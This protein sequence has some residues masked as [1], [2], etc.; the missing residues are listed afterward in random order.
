MQRLD[1]RELEPN[2]QRRLALPDARVQAAQ[3]AVNPRGAQALLYRLPTVG[4]KGSGG[5]LVFGVQQ[6]QV[7]AV[8]AGGVRIGAAAPP[9]ED[10]VDSGM[11]E[12]D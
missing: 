7:E 4:L 10:L 5:C 11:D 8:P 9:P 6:V 1:V 3:R 12:M 2:A